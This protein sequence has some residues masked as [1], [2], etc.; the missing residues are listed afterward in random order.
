MFQRVIAR[1]AWALTE[2]DTTNI[3]IYA[4]VESMTLGRYIDIPIFYKKLVLILA[5]DILSYS[6]MERKATS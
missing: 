3:K 2:K 5:G 6:I 1:P 4:M